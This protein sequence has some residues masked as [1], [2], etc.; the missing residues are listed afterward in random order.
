MGLFLL[1][2]PT[3]SALFTTMPAQDGTGGVEVAG[4]AYARQT[5]S[6]G[7][8]NTGAGAGW[9]S[10]VTDATSSTITNANDILFPVATPSGWGTIL[11]IGI[12]DLVSGGNLIALG[13]A[14]S[15]VAINAGDQYK[16]AA[17]N[18]SINLA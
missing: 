6:G 17:G 7:T 18:L 13:V 5:V 4:N 15:S 1:P 16:I 14:D 8:H 10:I 3:W 9:T 2:S 11:G 12:Y